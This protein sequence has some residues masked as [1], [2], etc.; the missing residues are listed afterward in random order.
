MGWGSAQLT[1]RSQTLQ[2]LRATTSAFFLS[3]LVNFRAGGGYETASKSG[4]ARG[5]AG[6][7]L[8]GIV[9]NLEYYHVFAPVSEGAIYPSL[10]ILG[11]AG[12]VEISVGGIYFIKEDSNR[13][14]Q[15]ILGLKFYLYTVD[16]S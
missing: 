10:S 5:G 8:L 7:G 3:F 13:K 12:P 2:P 16:S 4:F 6:L 15:L 11:W 1:S 14:N 9:F